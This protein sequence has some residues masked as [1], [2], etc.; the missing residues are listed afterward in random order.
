MIQRFAPFAACAICTLA[1]S[2]QPASAATIAQWNFNSVPANSNP[3]TGTLS[4]N[5]GNGTIHF[6]GG[7]SHSFSGAGGS[8]EDLSAQASDNSG[9]QITNFPASLNNKTAGLGWRV[10]TVGYRDIIVTWDQRHAPASSRFARFQYTL[11]A[12]IASPVWIDGDQFVSTATANPQWANGRSVNLTAVSGVSNNANAGFRVVSELGTPT[13]YLAARTASTYDA[14][15]GWWKF[16]MVT[17]SGTTVPEPATLSLVGL[18]AT[19]GLRR[20]R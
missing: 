19:L 3:D 10:S 5:Q 16:D 6:Y 17:V 7:V 12:S 20:R 13:D 9:L 4:P 15:V 11:D 18:V 8:S 14:V 1:G 2:T